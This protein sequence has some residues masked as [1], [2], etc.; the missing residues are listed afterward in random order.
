MASINNPMF[1]VHSRDYSPE[2]FGELESCDASDF[3]IDFACLKRFYS[4]RLKDYLH[5]Y[6]A[7][8]KNDFVV[9]YTVDCTFVPKIVSSVKI[10]S[11]LLLT[12]YLDGREMDLADLTWIVPLSGKINRWSQL[13]LLLKHFT[14]CKS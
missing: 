9:F 12:V 1:E 5:I 3:I 11:G 14:S 2:F 10:N 4:V 7:H 13:Q 8:F 6:K